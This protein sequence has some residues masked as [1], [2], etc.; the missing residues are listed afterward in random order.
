[1]RASFVLVFS[2]A[3]ALSAGPPQA[4]AAVA[5]SFAQPQAADGFGALDP[6]PPTGITVAQIIE[7]MGKREAQF[8]AARLQ[9]IFRQS[10]KVDTISEDTGRPDGEYQQVADITFD[11]DNRRAEHVVFAPQNTLE[12]VIMTPT[13]FD[14]IVNRQPFILTTEQLP[15]YDLTYL[16]RQKVDDLDT[17]VFDGEA[18]ADR[19]G[20]P[21]LPG[22]SVGRP[23]GC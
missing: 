8:A 9:Y 12:R 2:V 21:L 15:Q 23:A 22:Q 1:M 6:A 3:L 13:D 18:E 19:E 14:E 17:Y 4:F 10:V 5:N 7:K 20:A 16:G 11:K